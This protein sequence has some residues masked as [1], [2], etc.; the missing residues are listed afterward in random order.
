MIRQQ[1]LL[2]LSKRGKVLTGAGRRGYPW[3]EKNGDGG[4]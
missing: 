2:I 3:P 4:A 1:I